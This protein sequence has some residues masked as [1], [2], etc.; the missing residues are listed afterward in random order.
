M[1]PDYLHSKL[2][3][4]KSLRNNSKLIAP[5]PARRIAHKKSFF[6]SCIYAWNNII[7][8]EER[9]CASLEFFKTKLKSRVLRTKVNNF[10]ITGYQDV[11]Y[12][13]QLRVG[14]S[15]LNKH[16]FDHNFAGIAPFCSCGKVED[17]IHYLRSCPQFHPQRVRLCHQIFQKT[18]LNM[19]FC[20]PST[21][22]KTLLY[23]NE[24]F[25]D[26][27]NKQVLI[28]TKEYINK[29]NRFA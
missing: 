26:E 25:S 19:I 12:I 27:Q 21:F 1:A 11:K 9:E 17:T 2:H 5:H 16:R 3:F 8:S 13:N 14:L 29:T 10:K 4:V 6:P 24:R 18:S 28:L 7:S 23:G 15:A 20:S 22:C